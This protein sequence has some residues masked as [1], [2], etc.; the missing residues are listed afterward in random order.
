MKLVSIIKNERQHLSSGEGA[1]AVLVSRHPAQDF[2]NSSKLIVTESEEAIFLRDGL[3]VGVFGAGSYV[4]DTNNYP[5]LGRLLRRFTGNVQAF[6]CQVYF[7]DISHNLA[8]NWGTDPPIQMRDPKLRIHTT[9]QARGSFTV[10]IDDSKKLM[11]KLV[12]TNVSSYTS[13]D[14]RRGFRSAFAQTISDAIAQH[15]LD[16]EKEILAVCA[17]RGRI[18]NDLKPAL[19]PLLATYGLELVDFYVASIAIPQDDPNRQ[20]LEDAYSSKGVMEILG[21]DWGRQ[22]ARE[23][24]GDLANNPGPGGVAAMGAGAGLGIGAANVFGDMASQ[25]FKHAPGQ[26]AERRGDA[27]SAARD[28]FGPSEPAGAHCVCGASNQPSA[29]FCGQCGEGLQRTCTACGV[30]VTLGSKFCNACGATLN[31]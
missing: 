7:V 23:I 15:I 12:G 4:L 9:L 10:R 8:L 1:A 22:Q 17:D 26:P 20:K 25:M 30:H 6:S 29:K 5:W 31:Q 19:S 27:R 18:A 24:L 13:D 21:D 28:R 3:A 14:L 2:E 16:S 11:M